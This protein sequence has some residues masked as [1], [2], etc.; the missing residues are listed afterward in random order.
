MLLV[1]HFGPDHFACGEDDD[2]PGRA[3]NIQ[4]KYYSE[5]H[6]H[7]AVIMTNLGRVYR[8]LGDSVKV[9]DVFERAMKIEGKHLW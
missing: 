7:V 2:E 6:F 9:T 1:K 4:V 3:L 5:D 8:T